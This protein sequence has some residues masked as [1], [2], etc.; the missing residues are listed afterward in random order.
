MSAVQ[1]MMRL[2]LVFA[3]TVIRT[4]TSC[5][6]YMPAEYVSYE[7][8]CACHSGVYTTRLPHACVGRCRWQRAS[9]P[10]AFRTQ[11]FASFAQQTKSSVVS[12]LLRCLRHLLNFVPPNGCL[13]TCAFQPARLRQPTSPRRFAYRFRSGRLLK[14]CLASCEV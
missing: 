14:T 13:P 1:S 9:R 3:D 6:L 7:G 4:R 5:V 12:A 2:L 8:S 10:L 11:N